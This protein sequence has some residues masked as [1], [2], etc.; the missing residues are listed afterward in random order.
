M[1]RFAALTAALVFVA[2]VATPVLAA[3]GQLIH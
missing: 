3:A 1:T 2:A